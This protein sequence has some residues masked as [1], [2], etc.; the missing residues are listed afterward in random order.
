MNEFSRNSISNR[1]IV[2]GLLGLIASLTFGLKNHSNKVE[3]DI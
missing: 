2:M 3:I 1:Y